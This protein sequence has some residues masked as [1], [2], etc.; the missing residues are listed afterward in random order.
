MLEENILLKNE[1]NYR[2]GG[3][4]RFFLRAK[5]IEEL[6]SGLKEAA[7][8]KSN[9]KIFFLGGGTNVLA[10]DKG[11][12]G[13]I[14]K[15]EIGGIEIINQTKIKAGAGMT[16]E[17]L[18]QFCVNHALSGMEWS[19]GLPGTCGGGTFGNAGAFG[20]EMKDNIF[21]VE[22][23]NLKTLEIKT[24]DKKE[25]EFNYRSSIF[26]SKLRNQEII[27]SIIF[28]LKPGNR[29]E[30]LTS[31]NDKIT[32]RQE[33]Q[34]LELPSAGSTF[35]NVSV[36]NL[37]EK[38]KEQLKDKI[39]DDP[40]PVLPAAV[41]I[42]MAG[43]KGLQIGG[44]KVSEKHPNFIVNTGN[45]SALDVE[46]L[47]NKVIEEVNNQFSVILEPEVAKIV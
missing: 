28:D 11:Y 21:K 24:R 16:I 38:I 3:P 23:L 15:M 18:N 36:E 46:S 31:I 17:Q 13:L 39:K 32:Y 6:I 33:R 29:D 10:P 20:G 43:L 30:I 37:P 41:L 7:E 25:C 19:G 34:P 1:T 9:N 42:N 47:I 44:A 26:K 2:I 45:S 8:K 5:N 22:S 12:D 14:I 27:T 35:K 4:A 40:F